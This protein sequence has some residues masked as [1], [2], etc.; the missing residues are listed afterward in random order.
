LFYGDENLLEFIIEEVSL[1]VYLR[2]RFIFLILF[3]AKYQESRV[4]AAGLS[5]NERRW[6]QHTLGI[7]ACHGC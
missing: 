7:F 5:L 1:H 2:M 6:L 3:T 4:M